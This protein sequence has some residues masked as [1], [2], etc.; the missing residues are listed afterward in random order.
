M[1]I[2]S[3]VP[4]QTELLCDLGL[5][6][7]LVGIT[8]FCVHPTNLR[9]QKVIVGGTKQVNFEKIQALKPDVILC[10][11]EEN[12]LEMV[13]VLRDIAPVHVADVTT[14]EDVYDLIHEYGE[15]FSCVK[16][17]QQMV[18]K[19]QGL[20]QDWQIKVAEFPSLMVVYFIWKDPWMVAGGNTFINTLLRA[21]GFVNVF[22]NIERYP[23]ISVSVLQETDFDI[24][25]LSSEPYPFKEQHFEELKMYVPNAKIL[26]VDGEFFSWHG[27]RMLKAF[28]YFEKL[29]QQL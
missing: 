28:P 25:F 22:Q 19:L 11:K 3:L 23:E 2:V 29:R 5:Q 14:L 15:M 1:K 6:D 10:N 18:G 17:A 24:L 20:C 8:K 26:L 12:T 7:S 4:S 9:T 13:N 16:E 27:S 21:N